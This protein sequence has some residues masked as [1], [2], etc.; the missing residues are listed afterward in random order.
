MW[1]EQTRDGEESIWTES[2]R[3][4]I[5]SSPVRS[6]K[7]TSNYC[8]LSARGPVRSPLSI[9]QSV[10]DHSKLPNLVWTSSSITMRKPAFTLGWLPMISS[11]PCIICWSHFTLVLQTS[12]TSLP[13][14][15][16]FGYVHQWLTLELGCRKIVSQ[17]F[18]GC[19]ILGLKL[20][21]IIFD[22]LSPGQT[23]KHW[24]ETCPM[25]SRSTSLMSSAS[26]T[27]LKSLQNDL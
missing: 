18:H 21:T 19:F 2:R 7:F 16:I 13:L 6:R 11:S 17:L 5:T 8:K 10:F 4:S 12:T 14:F 9:S 22:P 15:F 26:L 1:K 23:L 20:C 3:T 27:A 24:G 25:H